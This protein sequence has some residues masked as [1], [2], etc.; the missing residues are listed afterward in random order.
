MN[1]EKTIMRKS[2][3]TI[4]ILATVHCLIINLNAQS[5]GESLDQVELMKQFTGTW[6][7]ETGDDTVI[8]VT[9]TPYGIAMKYERQIDI[10]VNG[11]LYIYNLSG[12]YGFSSDQKTVK[13]VGVEPSGSLNYDYGRFISPT[14]YVAENYVEDMKHPI[15]LEEV[16]FISPEV[17]V[18]RSR[19]RGDQMTWD[20]DWGPNITFKKVE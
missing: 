12:F 14:K 16:E 7:S 8:V 20:A 4:L 18:I 2:I 17:M 10:K 1:L 9:I 19:F 13:F 5:T 15:A 6:K 11:G 3:T